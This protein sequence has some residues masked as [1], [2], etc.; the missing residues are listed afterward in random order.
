MCLIMRFKI[1]ENLPIE[2]AEVIKKVG[3]EADT[4]S[5]EGLGGCPKSLPS[6]A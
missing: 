5:D 4:V 1:D 6:T 3:Y 2:C